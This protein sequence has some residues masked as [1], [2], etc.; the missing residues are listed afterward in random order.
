MAGQLGD[1]SLRLLSIS[2]GSADRSDAIAPR[3][4]NGGSMSGT[5][6]VSNAPFLPQAAE[7]PTAT[8][9][10]SNTVVDAQEVNATFYPPPSVDSFTASL[11]K[12]RL[13]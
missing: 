2:P 11:L 9:K 7:S 3:R 12:L 1:E 6:S 5:D 8:D 10:S 4:R 13:L